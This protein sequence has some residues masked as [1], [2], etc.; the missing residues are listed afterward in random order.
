MKNQKEIDELEF[1][2]LNL[3][4][5]NIERIRTDTTFDL[6]GCAKTLFLEEKITRYELHI[7]RY[8]LN[9]NMP[10]IAVWVKP[11]WYAWDPED[12]YSRIKF[13]DHIIKQKSPSI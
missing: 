7:L 3:L 9:K 13:L 1:K 10:P 5:D 11:Y 12:T 4:R 8:S 6:Y 2:L